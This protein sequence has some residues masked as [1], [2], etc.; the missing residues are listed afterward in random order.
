MFSRRAGSPPALCLPLLTSLKVT[1]RGEYFFPACERLPGLGDIREDLPAVDCLGKRT[2]VGISRH[3][4]AGGP[5]N[6]SHT[7]QKL[8]P[9][10]SGHAL[11]AQYYRDVMFPRKP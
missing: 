2:H 1:R 5:G 6:F 4:D 9:A 10:D 11:V 7:P 3:Y 8:V